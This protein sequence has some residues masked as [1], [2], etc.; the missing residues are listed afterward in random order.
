MTKS[1]NE[2]TSEELGRLFPILLSKYDPFWRIRYAEEKELLEKAIGLENIVRIN[3]YGSTSVPGLMA[4]PTIDILL[5]I[6]ENVNK[7][8]F[9][10]CLL[11][12]GYLY[13]PQPNNPPPHMMFMKGYTP[14][15]FV[16]QAY[17]LHVRYK[18]DWNELYFRD[19]LRIHPEVAAE[20][21][22]LKNRLKEQF[23]FDRDG[24]TEAKSDFIK[25]VTE[26]ART[27]FGG[28]YEQD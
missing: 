16:G 18:G 11:E 6:K 27:E 5:E 24:Y 23:E 17:H 25:R 15:G 19:Y 7:E 20:Y 14:H 13:S 21:E 8:E 9:I 26:K 28:R 4:K 3:H 12:T 1:L 22:L 10:A 2:L